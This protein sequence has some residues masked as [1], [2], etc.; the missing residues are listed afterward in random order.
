MA[1]PT[2]GGHL[3]SGATACVGAFAFVWATDSLKTRLRSRSSRCSPGRSS[4]P[5]SR[6]NRRAAAASGSPLQRPSSSGRSAWNRSGRRNRS[7]R[8]ARP[9]RNRGRLSLQV[10][11]PPP[12]CTYMRAFLFAQNHQSWRSLANPPTVR[13][14][15]SVSFLRGVILQPA[16]EQHR[17]NQNATSTARLAML[18]L[19]TR[20]LGGTQ[21]L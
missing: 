14:P 1:V 7:A 3:P 4:W 9:H 6:S 11:W 5:R 2:G 17:T 12:A 21:A 8:N 19:R 20:D 15:L 10:R 13:S 18:M 16:Q